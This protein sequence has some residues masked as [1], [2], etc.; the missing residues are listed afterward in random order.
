MVRPVSG[1]VETAS[2]VKNMAYRPETVVD[3]VTSY[4]GMTSSGFSVDDIWS[5]AEHGRRYFAV[6]LLVAARIISSRVLFDSTFNNDKQENTQRVQTSVKDHRT[7]RALVIL[8][9]TLV[10]MIYSPWTSCTIHRRTSEGLG[11]QSQL[12]NLSLIHI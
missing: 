3:D 11:Q 10:A 1:D 9:I 6:T 8:C 4:C 12:Q 2:P 5:T 7:K